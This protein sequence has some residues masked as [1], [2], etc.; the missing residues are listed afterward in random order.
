VRVGLLGAPEALRGDAAVNAGRW[1]GPLR[2]LDRTMID[3]EP[4]VVDALFGAGLARPLEGSAAE[5]I[6]EIDRRGLD[7]VGVDVPSGVHGVDGDVLP[8]QAGPSAA[9]RS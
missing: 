9:S 8:R 6:R 1:R 5:L 2:A 4:L 7:C 3:D